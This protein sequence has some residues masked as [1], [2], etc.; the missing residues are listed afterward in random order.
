VL[1]II[2]PGFPNQNVNTGILSWRRGYQEGIDEADVDL[3]LRFR[4]ADLPAVENVI[5]LIGE[6][7]ADVLEVTVANRTARYINLTAVRLVTQLAD[8]H[9]NCAS[10]SVHPLFDVTLNVA[11]SQVRGTLRRQVPADEYAYALRGRVIETC[12]EDVVLDA[13]GS[14]NYEIGPDQRAVFRLRINTQGTTRARAQLMAKWHGYEPTPNRWHVEF[15]VNRQL[16]VVSRES[17]TR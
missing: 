2:A 8:F 6:E 13:A 9:V 16:W 1:R 15:E 4:G 5:Q 3:P 10:R 7:T 12:G 11:G 17:R 14:L